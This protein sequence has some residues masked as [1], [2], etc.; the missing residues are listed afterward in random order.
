MNVKSVFLVFVM[1]A[2]ASS[3]GLTNDGRLFKEELGLTDYRGPT[4]R[5]AWVC[6][7]SIT[8][9]NHVFRTS[10]IDHEGNVFGF[11]LVGPDGSLVGG[12]GIKIAP[13]SEAAL[14]AICDHIR[15]GSSAPVQGSRAGWCVE[16]DSQGDVLFYCQGRRQDGDGVERRRFR[17]YR[18]YCNLYFRIAINTER[19]DLNAW[20]FALPLIMGGLQG[21]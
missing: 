16:R 19:T 9:S 10:R 11:D 8:I 20:D 15:L 4:N 17:F 3:L 7:P 18:T 14:D 6:P 2:A 13:S 5:C 12:C 21:R 1:L